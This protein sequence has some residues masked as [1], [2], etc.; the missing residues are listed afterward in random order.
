M[1]GIIVALLSVLLPFVHLGLSKRPRTRAH[2]IHLLLRY[3]LVLQ[4]AG[5]SW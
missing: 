3:T 5:T 4:S 2:V 1:I